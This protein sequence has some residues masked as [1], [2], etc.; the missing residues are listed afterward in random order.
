MPNIMPE[1]IIANGDDENCNGT[2]DEGTFFEF[3]LKSEEQLMPPY[4]GYPTK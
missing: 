2:T 1:S 4:P 3:P